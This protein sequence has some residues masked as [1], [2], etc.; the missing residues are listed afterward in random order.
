[1][2]ML[3]KGLVQ[4]FWSGVQS[5][6]WHL[7]WSW[8]QFHFVLHIS[9]MDNECRVFIGCIQMSVFHR[10][11]RLVARLLS[12]SSQRP[13]CGLS[14]DFQW[15]R[16]TDLITQISLWYGDHVV[17]L[18]FTFF[19]DSIKMILELSKLEI[20]SPT[21]GYRNHSHNHKCILSV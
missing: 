20:I 13:S 3:V 15:V 6:V 8:K 18:L 19:N 16:F 21:S 11:Y 4:V 14:A 17:K 9:N 7:H 5:L 12:T 1:M 2:W 10:S